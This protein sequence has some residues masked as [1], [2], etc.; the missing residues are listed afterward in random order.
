MRERGRS[1]VVL[2]FGRWLLKHEYGRV[3]FAILVVVASSL[4]GLLLPGYWDTTPWK[5]WTAIADATTLMVAVVVWYSEA[6]GRRQAQLPR[7]LTVEFLWKRPND[8][9]DYKVALRCDRVPLA[10]PGDA[11]AWAQQLARQMNGGVNLEF[12]VHFE[13]TGP[14]KVRDTHGEY[15]HYTVTFYLRRLTGYAEECAKDGKALPWVHWTPENRF[16]GEW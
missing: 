1:P 8:E 5:F 11:R 10:H 2:G 12:G 15:M 4:A 13:N 6:Q 3:W 7:R 9:A 16:G 14:T